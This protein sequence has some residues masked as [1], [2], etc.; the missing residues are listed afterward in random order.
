VTVELE[1]VSL[2]PTSPGPTCFTTRMMSEGIA[3]INACIIYSFEGVPL[4]HPSKK[5][6]IEIAQILG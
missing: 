3:V 2:V 6:H 5:H 1:I 4:S